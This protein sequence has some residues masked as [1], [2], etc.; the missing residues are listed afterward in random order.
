MGLPGSGKSTLAFNLHKLLP[1]SVWLNAD[2]VRTLHNDWD[3]SSE[4]RIR[5]ANRMKSLATT[6][7][8]VDYIVDMVCPVI[9]TRSIINADFVVWMDTINEGRYEDTNKLF[10]NP[11][12]YDIRITEKN[13]DKYASMIYEKILT[14]KLTSV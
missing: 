12:K 11:Y 8:T 1:N 4:G 13:A 6:P 2:A 3:F 14:A 5:Q 7:T 10:E 9:E